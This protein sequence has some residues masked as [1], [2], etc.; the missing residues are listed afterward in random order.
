MVYFLKKF[1][2]KQ[3]RIEFFNT[4]NSIFKFNFRMDFEG[5]FFNTYDYKI[6]KEKKIG[7]GSFGIV[8]E[9]T[10]LND[11]KKYAVKIIKTDNKFNGNEQMTFM[12]E[13]MILHKL[14]HPSIL[15]F[16]G[17]N[18]QSFDDN[19]DFEPSIITEYLSNGSLHSILAKEK[20]GKKNPKWNSTKKYKCLLGIADAMRYLHKQGILHL[21]LKPLNILIDD[22]FNPKI[23][24]FGLSKCFPESFTKSVKMTIKNI[25]GSPLYMAPEMLDDDK[26]FGYAVDVYAFG[27]IA[28]QI[29]TENE[30][31]YELGEEINIFQIINAI[32]SDFKHTFP[33]KVPI[34]TKN[35]IEKCIS[36]NPKDRPSFDEIFSILSNDLSFLG[37]KVD[38]HEIN[39]YI[40]QLKALSFSSENLSFQ[41]KKHEKEKKCYTSKHSLSIQ[42]GGKNDC[43]ER[44]FP[45]LI[46][47]NLMINTFFLV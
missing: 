41:E 43:F 35:L 42:H 15:N 22:D 33:Q 16:I 17:I 12:R 34:K 6:D 25:E 28:Y 2:I 23:G 9:A 4:L 32:Q 13:S 21:D 11:N 20:K 8:Y 26:H 31:F 18:F 46:F 1:I 24:D 38:E 45:T 7:E 3:L 19:Y 44:M 5:V 36:K 27:L 10:C 14:S 40:L 37:Q 47:K 30:P 39:S 29:V